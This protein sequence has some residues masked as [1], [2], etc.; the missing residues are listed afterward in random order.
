MLKYSKI[1]VCTDAT[2]K[3]TNS[4]NGKVNIK[5]WYILKKNKD[6]EKIC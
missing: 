6:L 4:T 1:S 5:K 2:T 3:T